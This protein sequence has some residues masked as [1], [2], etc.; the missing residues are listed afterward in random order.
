[1]EWISVKDRLPE[2]EEAILM[3]DVFLS[4][5]P[6]IGWYEKDNITPGFFTADHCFRMRS[7]FL[8]GSKCPECNTILKYNE[9]YDSVYCLGCGVWLDSA[10]DDNHCFFCSKR[11]KRPAKPREVK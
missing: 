3:I 8:A 2:D 7:I 10:C 4:N 6:T 9:R 1:M 11:P 5:I